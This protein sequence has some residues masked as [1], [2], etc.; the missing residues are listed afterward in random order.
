VVA[1]YESQA[2]FVPQDGHPITGT[3]AI[4]AAIASFAAMRPKLTMHIAKTVAFGPDLAV[5][6]NDWTMTARSPDGSPVEG[7]GKAIEIVRRQEDGSWLF[8]LDDPFAR[9]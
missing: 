6:Y 3:A 8:V 5:I 9:S 1:L 4:R 7:S 2:T